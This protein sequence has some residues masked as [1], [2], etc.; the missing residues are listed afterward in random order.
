M[1]VF[2]PY[3]RFCCTFCCI[4]QIL[5]FN[6]RIE[7]KTSHHSNFEFNMDV[8]VIKNLDNLDDKID[9][10]I[11][12]GMQ[13][14]QATSKNFKYKNFLKQTYKH[15]EKENI[16]V[17]KKTKN[18]LKKLIQ[19]RI[20][21]RLFEYKKINKTTFSNQNAN[22]KQATITKASSEQA[23]SSNPRGNY[24]NDFR[25]GIVEVSIGMVFIASEVPPLQA[26]GVGLVTDGVIKVGQGTINYIWPEPGER[27][28]YRERER[29]SRDGMVH[30]RDREVSVRGR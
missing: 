9:F 12:A 17:D 30:E 22:S 4:A 23:S 7:A 28:H 2:R 25:E 14:Q 6:S 19:D 13:Y 27:N 1:F 20:S 10:F 15:L 26:V 11:D 18:Y 16:H 24:S 3:Y 21:E 5:S 8:T 29:P